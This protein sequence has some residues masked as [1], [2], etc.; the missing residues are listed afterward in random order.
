MFI[1]HSSAIGFLIL[2]RGRRGC[3]TALNVCYQFQI[4]GFQ[5]I[6]QERRG[7]KTTFYGHIIKFRQKGFLIFQSRKKMVQKLPMF[8][9]SFSDKRG[10][11][12]LSVSQEMIGCKIILVPYQFQTNGFMIFNQGRWCKKQTYTLFHLSFFR[13]KN[14]C[15]SYSIFQGTSRGWCQKEKPFLCS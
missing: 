8:I 10:C 7:F 1:Y 4:K 5:I 2:N 3:K 12:I 14:G 11:P 9:T 6:N 15:L 13:Q